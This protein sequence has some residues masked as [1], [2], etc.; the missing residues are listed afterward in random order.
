MKTA[1]SIFKIFLVALLLAVQVHF[2]YAQTAALLPVAPQQ[3]FDKN[4]NPV[5]SGSVGYYIP[6]TSTPK[7]VWQDDSQTTPWSN[8]IT[9]NAGGW[10]PNNKGIYG[11][12]TY[13][14]IIKDKYNNII[15]DL[16]VMVTVSVLF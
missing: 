8:P 4:G 15:S 11:N 1:N 5:T 10:P 6:G 13:R 12:G 7:M 2:A 3:F 16:L 9:L 14:Q